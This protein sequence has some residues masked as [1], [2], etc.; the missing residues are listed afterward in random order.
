MAAIPDASG[1]PAALGQAADAR[2]EAVALQPL[3]DGVVLNVVADLADD[4]RRMIRGLR[5]RVRRL[6]GA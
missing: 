4:R 2:I 3:D 6:I 1:K 5:M